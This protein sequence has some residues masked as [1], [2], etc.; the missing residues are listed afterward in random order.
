L[1]IAQSSLN[2]LKIICVVELGLFAN[3]ASS[4]VSVCS[5]IIVFVSFHVLVHAIGFCMVFIPFTVP[6]TSKNTHER[7]FSTSLCSISLNILSAL[8]PNFS[9][10]NFTADLSISFPL[11]TYNGC[12]LKNLLSTFAKCSL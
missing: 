3:N 4:E 6:H 9:S 1:S 10:R 8:I 11:C 7:I 5:L 12:I 2:I